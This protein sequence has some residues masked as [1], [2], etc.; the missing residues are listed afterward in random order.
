MRG[1]AAVVVAL[2]VIAV[3]LFVVAIVVCPL[4][5][6]SESVA[7]AVVGGAV[8]LPFAFYLGFRAAKKVL[9]GAG[10]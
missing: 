9:A 5:I 10:D 8:G 1:F 6:A 7:V 2:T 4:A 3:G